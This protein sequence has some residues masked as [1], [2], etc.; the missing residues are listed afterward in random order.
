MQLGKALVG[1]VIG[2]ALGIGLLVA[3]HM[4]TGLDQ[5]WLAIP[6]ALLTGLGVRLMVATKG[7][8]S[9]FR[10]AV[11][12]VLALAAF[13]VGTQLFAKVAIRQANADRAPAPIVRAEKAGDATDDAGEAAVMDAVETA[14]LMERPGAGGVA[15]RKVAVRRDS[16]MDYIWLAVAGLLAYELGRGT[17]AAAPATASVA[18]TEDDGTPTD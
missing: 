12:C 11:T 3:I 10:G 5:Y 14:P 7:H 6:V 15:N 1:A 2:G 4:F 18:P 9:Y 16:P 8:A 13:L 17:T